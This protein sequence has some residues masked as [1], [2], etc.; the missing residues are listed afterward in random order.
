AGGELRPG[1]KVLINGAGGGV[2]TFALQ[3][4]KAAGAEV[5]AVDSAPKLEMLRALG[6]DQVLDYARED[7]TRTGHRYDLIL[8]VKTNRPPSAYGRALEPGGTYATVGGSLVRLLQ[9]LLLGPV[10]AR[11]RGKRLRVVMLRPNRDLALVEALFH[12][13]RLVP[14]IDGPRPL[15]ELPDALR[16]FG[17][18]EHQ[19]K[20]ILVTEAN[21][22]A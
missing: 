7:F 19:G 12:A 15:A 14:V 21:Q 2:G 5:T 8:D 22:S 13:G 4:A 20:V 10:Y 1:Q 17:R 11:F 9:A 16:I 18:A 3:I 6:A